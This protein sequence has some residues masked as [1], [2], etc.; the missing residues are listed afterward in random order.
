M[1]SELAIHPRF[2]VKSVEKIQGRTFSGQQSLNNTLVCTADSFGH[3][4]ELMEIAWRRGGRRFGRG[5]LGPL[6]RE[7]VCGREESFPCVASPAPPHARSPEAS[8]PQHL[9]GLSRETCEWGTPPFAPY[10]KLASPQASQ[11]FTA[12]LRSFCFLRPG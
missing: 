3:V 10:Y 12:A 8:C 7:A 2:L 9:P 1:E 4:T 5:R 6:L 11:I